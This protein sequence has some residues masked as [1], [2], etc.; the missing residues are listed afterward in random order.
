MPFPR[1]SNHCFCS[2]DHIKGPFLTLLSN[3]ELIIPRHQISWSSSRPMSYLW[4]HGFKSRLLYSWPSYSEIWSVP[5]GKMPGYGLSKIYHD[6]I[7]P[8]T[9][10]INCSCIIL[11]ETGI[12]LSVWWLSYGC[13]R[14]K[15]SSSLKRS[16]CL[17]RLSNFLFNGKSFLG[18][19]AAGTWIWQLFLHLVPSLN[20][21]SYTSNPPYAFMTIITLSYW[22]CR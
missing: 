9:F 16:D 2:N 20:K 6:S 21:W 14:K 4:G 18:S 12:A 11:S 17:C 8:H 13:K 5:P 19:T 3:L 15:S 10:Y 7:F 22:N 1:M